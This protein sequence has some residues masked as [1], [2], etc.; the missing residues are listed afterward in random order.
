VSANGLTA[1]CAGTAHS[2]RGVYMASYPGYLARLARDT[3]EEFFRDIARNAIVGRYANYPSY[4]YR[5]GYTTLHQQPDYPLRPFEEIK[6]FTSAHYNHPLPMAAFLVDYL[7][8]DFYARSDGRIQ[9]P[10]D[11]TNTGAFF[12][13]KVY[14]ARPG[15]FYDDTGVFLWL[16]KALLATDTIQLNHLAAHGN[17]RLYLAFAN[18]SARPVSATVR[19]DAA[20]V[21]APGPHRARIWTDNQPATATTIT[22]GIFPVTVSPKGLTC[23]ALDDVTIHTEIQQAM[24]DRRSPPLP[25]GSSVTVATAF[26]PVTATA[27]RFGRGL[28][29]VH[30]WLKADPK[31]VRRMVVACGDGPAVACG[32]FPFEVTLPVGDAAPDSSARV[33][34]EHVDGRQV[35]ATAHVRLR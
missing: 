2:H 9:F 19:L 33:T 25:V 29:T 11:Y 24:L 35:S 12:R 28:T 23:V 5:N 14:G 26:G 1:E 30:V 4:A 21:S 3:G 13:N 31:T 20:R 34:V 6:K 15:R 17:G 18:Q 27:L 22:G 10:S 7:V 16:P 8:S 32:E